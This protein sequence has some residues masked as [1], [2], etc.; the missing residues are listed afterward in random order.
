LPIMAMERLPL[1]LLTETFTSSSL[2]SNSQ[3]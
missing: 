2:S 3:K 1:K